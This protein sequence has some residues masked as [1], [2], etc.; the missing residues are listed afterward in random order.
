MPTH[1]FYELLGAPREA[2][3]PE[4][5]K[6]FGERVEEFGGFDEVPE[7][8]HAAYMV[9]KSETVRPFYDWFLRSVESATPIECNDAEQEQIRGYCT[10]WG[11]ELVEHPEGPAGTWLIRKRVT[12]PPAIPEL[13]GSPPT[14]S[15][16]SGPPSGPPAQ[17][18]P[19]RPD[20]QQQ[21]GSIPWPPPPLTLGTRIYHWGISQGRVLDVIR[22]HNYGQ[23]QV[24]V[25]GE[26]DV[27][28][29]K[30]EELR[31][32]EAAPGDHIQILSLSERAVTNRWTYVSFIN[33]TRGGLCPLHF[34]IHAWGASTQYSQLPQ[35]FGVRNHRAVEQVV[36]SFFYE[37]TYQ[38]LRLC[39]D[40]DAS[41]RQFAS[42]NASQAAKYHLKRWR[43]SR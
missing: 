39:G 4:I 3:K 36:A 26:P 21:S 20:P 5:D 16:P 43:N 24:Q 13:G 30:L 14:P 11:Y 34:M 10:R 9:L 27:K 7:S 32:A 28:V 33:M 23:F 1:S 12:R 8:V 19:P 2:S 31:T 29:W 41:A 25:E 18:T 22:A 42:A 17:P 37:V 6:A 38:T 15:P 35:Y 40:S